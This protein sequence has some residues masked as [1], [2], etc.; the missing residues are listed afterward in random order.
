MKN[1]IRAFLL[2]AWSCVRKNPVEVTLSI[3][4]TCFVHLNEV[5]SLLEEDFLYLYFP[6]LFLLTH[7]LNRWTANT[8][9]RMVY[10]LSILCTIPFALGWLPEN[11]QICFVS[12]IVVQLLYF[13]QRKKNRDDLEFIA[14][15]V[16]YSFAVMAAGVFSAVLGLLIISINA[17]I[18]YIFDTDLLLPSQWIESGLLFTILF[19]VFPLLF[20]VFNDG[21]SETVEPKPGQ[22]IFDIPFNYLLTPAL[23]IYAV[24]LY[25]YIIKV[26][27][28]WSLPKGGVA[29]IVVFFSVA[30]IALK[31]F[32]PV[33]KS[34]YRWFY[35]YI[36]FIVLPPLALYWVGAIYRINQYG[37]TEARV[38]LVLLGILLTVVPLLFIFRNNGRLLYGNLTAIVL[39]S[40][41]T[42]IP[43]ITAKDIEDYSQNRRITEIE[44]M[45]VE[46]YNIEAVEI[47]ARSV[48]NFNLQNPIDIAKYK[49]GERIAPN[50]WKENNGVLNVYKNEQLVYSCNLN[51]MFASQ[52]EKLGL[53]TYELGD[54]PQSRYNDLLQV[55]VNDSTVLVLE[56]I[57]GDYDVD[58][59]EFDVYKVTP[60]LFLKR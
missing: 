59:G 24:I 52:L 15:T 49:S 37:F 58:S 17:S 32:Q 27:F 13:M 10:Y 43:G 47:K 11:G 45:A 53:Y 12:F 35:Q 39:I 55:K 28:L 50:S 46:L 30:A 21:E 38:Y 41:V 19:L 54:V 16:S 44:A 18:A 60:L 40:V 56:V 4:F 2:H 3:L 34:F 25:C 14:D 57:S 6:T 22:K 23:I 48:F 5:Y 26:L 33:I 51:Q 8:S 9:V 29:Y 31:S 7:T 42:F 1:R 20:L 36:E